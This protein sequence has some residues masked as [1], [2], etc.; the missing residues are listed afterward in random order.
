MTQEEAL[1]FIADLFQ[2]MFDIQPEQVKPE[3]RLYEDLELDSIDAVDMTVHLQKQTGRKINAEDFRSVMTV[4]DLMLVV[5][6]LQATDGS[7]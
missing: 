1:Q 4:A 2:E 7:D 5:Q 6:K 3:A